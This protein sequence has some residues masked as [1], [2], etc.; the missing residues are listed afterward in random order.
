MMN[1]NTRC[2]V[3]GPYVASW[4]RGPDGNPEGHDGLTGIEVVVIQD[5]GR[6]TDVLCWSRDP[7]AERYSGEGWRADGTCEVWIPRAR[8]V[9]IGGVS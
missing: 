2:T 7:R 4:N 6:G 5:D 9:K 8:L 3:A 1:A